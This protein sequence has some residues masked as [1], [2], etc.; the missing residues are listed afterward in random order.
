MAEVE[1]KPADTAP[2]VP[3]TEDENKESVN[4]KSNGANGD[5]EIGQTG[6]STKPRD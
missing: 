5:G 2:E 3:A 6:R 1:Q 4:G